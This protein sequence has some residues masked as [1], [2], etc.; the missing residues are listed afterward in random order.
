MRELEVIELLLSVA[1]YRRFVLPEPLLCLDQTEA[2]IDL[3][4]GGLVTPL[5]HPTT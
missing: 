2:T 4:L 3:V 5:V 1:T